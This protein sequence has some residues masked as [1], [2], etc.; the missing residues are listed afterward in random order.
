MTNTTKLWVYENAASP[1]MAKIIVDAG[2]RATY[3]VNPQLL[4]KFCEHLGANIYHG[5]E[6]QILFN[7]TFGK[8]RFSA[9]DNHVDG[10][11]REETDRER[12]TRRIEM[13]AERA[14]WPDV[15]RVVET[16]YRGGAYGWFATDGDGA[17]EEVRLSPD[18][19]PYGGRAQRIE[20]LKASADAPGGIG[21]WTYLPLHR[22][23]TFRFRIVARAMEPCTLDLALAPADTGNPTSEA[24]IDLGT[25]WQTFTGTLVVPAEAPA[26]ALY[27]SSRSRRPTPTHFV[28]DRVLLY[29]DDS[30]DGADP[31]VIRMLK[32]AQLPLLRW[33]GGN[34]VS[35]YHWRDG[36]GPVDARPTLPNPA[37]E[38]LEFNLFG[39][40]EFVAF[41]RAV[42]CE[43]MICVNAGNGTAEEAAAWV[44]YCN[45]AVDTPMGHLRAENGHP[46]PYNIRLW[47]I[48]NEIY[49]HWQVGW[50]TPGGNVDRYQRFRAAILA[51]D[52]TVH[53]LGC[54]YGNEPDSEWNHRLIDEAAET[55]QTIT[56]HILTG[57]SVNSD[58]DPVE[59]YQAFMGYPSV[60][61]QRYRDL[62]ARMRH[63]GITEPHLAITELQLFAHF[64]GEA[65]PEGKLTPAMM[66]RPD[67]VAEALSLTEIVN[68]CIRL[69]DFVELITH[70]ATVNHG[71]GLRKQRERVYATP[72][73]TPTRWATPLLGPRPS[74]CTWPARPSPPNT[75]SSTSHR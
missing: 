69:G 15:T 46:D 16:Y 42:G 54:G 60:L 64:Q 14:E 67:T 8:W 38:G 4:G 71:G 61:E 58:T 24:K 34:F 72:S 73:I 33:P 51:V 45:G 52:P 27:R 53:I 59:L 25:G 41:C 3:R 55:L 26:E 11:V 63:A 56:D 28:L 2:T 57:G 20:V 40:D 68:T 65:T 30:V 29:P 19:S 22:I 36:V 18:V 49:G 47:E 44:E 21:Q 1:G 12:V 74:P 35:G 37:W 48:G 43:P 13:Y 5:M 66:P 9:G 75:P 17:E 62:E 7:P 70:S 39:T 23:R 6:A 10:G 32:E 50:T 31:D